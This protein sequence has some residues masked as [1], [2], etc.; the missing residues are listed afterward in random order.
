MG[1]N[2]DSKVNYQSGN[3]S[4]LIT[5]CSLKIM[6][7]PTIEN[8]TIQS[9]N[10]VAIELWDGLDLRAAVH[11]DPSDRQLF[12]LFGR[13]AILALQNNTQ[14]EFD[15]IDIRN[16]MRV[17]RLIQLH[18][19]GDINFNG[20]TTWFNHPETR[21]S[22]SKVQPSSGE[23]GA[24]ATYELLIGLAGSLSKP[25]GTKHTTLA[26]RILF[27][28]L[29]HLQFFNLSV[30]IGDALQQ[31]HLT[32][33]KELWLSLNRL[34]IHHGNFLDTLVKPSEF[35]KNKD[36]QYT[37]IANTGKWWHRRVMD[38]AILAP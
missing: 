14:P 6:P 29:P 24:E 20:L 37:Q 4:L 2:D 22:L 15:E 3:F 12:Y 1:L 25:D 31:N 19:K 27:F 36:N 26:S 9:S 8:P 23:A 34:V 32:E 33:T 10:K 38:L 28:L 7:I 5:F 13:K 30:A 21:A 17:G 18:I 35:Q 16:L 11:N